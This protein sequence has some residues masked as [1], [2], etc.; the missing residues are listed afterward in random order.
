[1]LQPHLFRLFV[2]VCRVFLALVF[3]SGLSACKT[4]DPALIAGSVINTFASSC[5]SSGPWS[6]A[7]RADTQG[8]IKILEELKANDKCQSLGP[9]LQEMSQT[10]S[11]IHAAYGDTDYLAYRQTEEELQELTIA[12]ASTKDKALQ[13]ELSLAIVERQKALAV[14]RA[15]RTVRTDVLSSRGPS[16]QYSTTTN[17]VAQNFTNMFNYSGQ[18]S[19]CLQ[20]SPTSVLSLFS[21]LAS[22]GGSFASPVLGSNLSLVSGMLTQFLTY[23]RHQRIDEANCLSG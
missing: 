17:L 22:I 15:T 2:W 21:N 16:D 11:N 13:D 4:D 23:M 10:A 8:L 20:Q 5:S 7:A 12:L 1:M 19:E 6:G 3:L 9:I 14:N 18:L